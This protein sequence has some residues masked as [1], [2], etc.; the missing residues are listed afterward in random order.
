MS[1]FQSSRRLVRNVLDYPSQI[2]SEKRW[3]VLNQ[4][5]L[6][7]ASVNELI[8][9]AIATKSQFLVG[10][11]G[12]TEGR[13]VEEFVRKRWGKAPLWEARKYGTWARRRGPEWSGIVGDGAADFDV[14][15]TVYIR[16]ILASDA[17]FVTDY[18]SSLFS[19]ARVL[20]AS[21]VPIGD[22][23][24]LN[25]Y[26]AL[27]LGLKPWTRALEGKRV[28][29][30]HP[31]ETSIRNQYDRR[32]NITGVSQILPDFQLDILKPP[33]TFAGENESATWLEQFKAAEQELRSRDFDVMI[34]GA[35]GYGLPLAQ[36]ARDMGKTAIHLGGLVQTL[37]GIRG[38]RFQETSSISVMMDSTWVSPS[39][40]ET[41]RQ[42]S[43]VEDGA[44][45]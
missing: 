3:D 10:R 39:A 1:F 40:E 24:H 2:I 45:W 5:L 23:A 41:P 14:F 12:G 18:A 27:K 6:D 9:R 16:S 43:R 25:P 37:F 11:P 33:V 30:V 8:M 4:D 7:P 44:Y 32:E 28:L 17:L 13:L 15:A 42:A 29:V 31:F 20:S 34:S 21:G 35:G 36:V 19:W 22:M 38:K 26:K